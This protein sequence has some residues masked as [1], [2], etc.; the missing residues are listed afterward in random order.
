VDPRPYAVG[1]IAEVY[2]TYPSIGPVLP[3]MGYSRRQL[4]ELAETIR[5]VPCDAVV[6]GTPI[7]LG[8]VVGDVGHPVRRASYELHETGA[9]TLDDVVRGFLHTCPVRRT[10][11][12]GAR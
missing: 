3:A 4:H 6:A 8:R 1:S 11:A 10:A 2:R 9:L 7:D 12:E 5:L